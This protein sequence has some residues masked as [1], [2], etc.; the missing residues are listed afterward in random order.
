[1]RGGTEVWRALELARALNL[2]RAGEPAP[3]QGADGI[4]RRRLLLALGGGA[5]AAS[6]PRTRALAAARQR[7]IVVGGGLAGLSALSRLRE[8]GVDATLYEARAAVGGRTRSVRGVFAPDYAFDEGGQLVNSDHKDM[9]ALVR[10]LGLKLVDRRS[11]SA[12]EIQ[13][14]RDGKP[15]AERELA[16]AL[17][18]IAAA[19]TADADRLDRD[20]GKVAP[21][22]DLLSAREY[23]DLHGL[24][25]GAARD[26]LEAAIRTEYGVEPERASAIELIFNQ[27]TV[28][29]QRVTRLSN[30]DERYVVAGGA[31][32]VAQALGQRLVRFIQLG[33]R[34][35]RI[36]LQGEGVRLAFA[37]GEEVLA[38]RVVLA[39]PA[40]LLRE[41]RIDGPLPPLWR[42]AISE[43]DLGRN[44]KVVAGYDA[45]PWRRALG[46]AG[47]LWSP[48]GFSAAWDAASTTPRPVS[49]PGAL[50]WFLGGGQVELAALA[51]ASDIAARFTAAGRAAIPGLPE[52]NGRVR[53]TQWHKDPL[54]KGS[55][56]NFR[57][58]QLTRFAALLTVE[59]EGQVR[60]SSAGPIVFAGEWLSDAWP[61]YMNGAVQTGR[62][63]A[64]AAV[65]PAR[66][67]AA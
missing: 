66:A 26:A 51:S 2:E 10:R 47:A 5:V 58:G 43:I 16:E 15:V 62:I 61:G 8:R 23:L 13:I 50:T 17:R 12:R 30:S 4:T 53:R 45:Q 39:L 59:E 19:I 64:D 42:Q 40:P 35:E 3:I 37:D 27:P 33:K 14:G 38:D 54:T 46:E 24:L 41:L 28:D 44:E 48:T 22:L 36:E 63:A 57:P 21:A 56:V 18:G 65:A 34:L 67:L 6:L 49:G 11:Q 60:A 32:Q 52:P 29:G 9:I 25:P 20:Y 31:G 7:V 1:M 55:Y